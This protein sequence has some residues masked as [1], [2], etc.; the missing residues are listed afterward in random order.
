MAKGL[1]LRTILIATAIASSGVDCLSTPDIAN[2]AK[3]RLQ[4]SLSSLAKKTTLS[5]EIIIP[6]P[7]DPT[8][9]LLQATDVSKLSQG[10]RSKAKANA[11]FITGSLNA[12]KS[13]CNE[14][15]SARG[16]FPSPLPVIYC[17]PFKN[18]SMDLELEDLAKT[19]V[20]GILYPVLNGEELS[21]I[22]ELENDSHIESLFQSAIENGM[23]LIPEIVISS[24]A[25][26]D[27]EKM[28]SLIDAVSKK[29]GSDPTAILLTVDKVNEEEEEDKGND[30]EETVK[31][32]FPKV[33]KDASSIILGSIRAVAGGG[34]IGEA[35]TDCKEAGCKGVVL[36]C[37]CLPGFRM[38]PDLD[39]VQKF[40]GAAIGDLKS[41]K[42]KSFDFRSKN[43]MERNIPMEWFNYQKDVMESG[44]LGLSEVGPTPGDEDNGDYQGF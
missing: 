22:S 44:A 34:R 28:G 4:E 33:P 11:A 16:G 17:D 40:W 26:W 7:S 25:E 1:R 2:L 38:N 9:L 5:P 18:G 15:E 6:E 12:V 30:Q 35:V 41:L 13:F 23:Q 27:E 31:K 39:F 36:R 24:D 3:S 20:S 32:S 10:L 14:Q 21:Q 19:G 42:S 29:C 37:D 8:A 43:A